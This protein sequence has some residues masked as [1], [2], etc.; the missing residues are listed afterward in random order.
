MVQRDLK[1]GSHTLK[2][3]QMAAIL[4][5]PFKIWKNPDFEWSGFLNGWD[6]SYSP[7][8][9]KPNNL[10][11]KNPDFVWFSFQMAGTIALA[12][13]FETQ[14]IWILI[15]WAFLQFAPSVC[16]LFAHS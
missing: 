14:T 1:S 2:S 3:G 13:L 5:K 11:L 16:L 7:T 10:K 4:S 12:H 6:L 8:L 15:P 9:W